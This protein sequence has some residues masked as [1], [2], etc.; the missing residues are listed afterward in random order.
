MVLYSVVLILFD[1][2]EREPPLLMLGTFL[3]GFFIAGGSAILLNTAFHLALFVGTGSEGV[4]MLGTAVISAPVIEEA[5]KGLAVLAVFL[6][7]RSEFDS[8]LDGVIYGSLVGFGFA[9]AENTSYIFRG[10]SEGGLGGLLFLAFIRAVVVGFMHATFTSFIGI[11]LAVNRLN[12]GPL[13]WISPVMGYFTAVALHAFHNLLGSLGD[14]RVCVIGSL[15]DWIGF[16]GMFL[17]ILY[18][19][20]H[21]GRVLR[22]HLR[23][24]VA[25][26][27]LTPAQYAT[28][29]SVSGQVGARLRGLAGGTAEGRLYDACGELAFK[30]YQLARLGAGREPAAQ[31]AIEALR[32]RLRAEQR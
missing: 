11:G 3:W 13:A 4:S 14:V 19:V 8:I 26:G 2:W 5:L 17:F 9:A 30:K 15:I 22:E 1:R 32:A 25:L 16:V 6:Y 24:E 18:L 10:F 7:F 29:C 31:A 12:Q 28:A 21:E 23:E 27:H 20:W